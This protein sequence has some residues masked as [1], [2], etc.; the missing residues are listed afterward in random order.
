MELMSDDIKPEG[1]E[2][3]IPVVEIDGTKVTIKVGSIPHPMLPEHHIEWIELITE[4]RTY[5]KF[6]DPAKP[7]QPIAIFDIDAKIVAARAYCNI[8]GLRKT[9][10]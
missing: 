9:N 2:K 1:Q 8:H 7:D 4:N 5:K 6:L 3:H 10:I